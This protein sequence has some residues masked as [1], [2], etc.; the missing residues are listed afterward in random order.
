[1]LTH[2]TSRV[3]FYHECGHVEELSTAHRRQCKAYLSQLYPTHIPSPDIYWEPPLL[4]RQN[5]STCKRR[6]TTVYY[7]GTNLC[8]HCKESPEA[9]STAPLPE[10]VLQESRLLWRRLHLESMQARDETVIAFTGLKKEREARGRAREW[11]M[12][13]EERR[14]EWLKDF[15]AY[16]AK[17]ERKGTPM[18]ERLFVKELP[19]HLW[20]IDWNKSYVDWDSTGIFRLV[21]ADEVAKNGMC[22]VC[23]EPL[24]VESARKL[25]CGHAFH[26][27]C[28]VPFLEDDYD[29]CDSH[30]PDKE[31][32]C[33][34][35]WTV[36]TMPSFHWDSVYPKHKAHLGTAAWDNAGL[37]RFRRFKTWIR[38]MSES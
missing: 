37:D 23:E 32:G 2:C 8:K 20:G 18:S 10:S 26:K 6:T 19:D 36:K 13:P 30:C 1:M 33:K 12:T 15:A 28:C 5:G 11:D 17:E 38:C 35:E 9:A 31:D 22:G 14:E 21:N 3:Q 25:P 29:G 27:D 16:R 4:A 7:D 24:N 34:G